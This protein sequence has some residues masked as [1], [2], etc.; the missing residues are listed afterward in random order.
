[1]KVARSSRNFA[2]GVYRS[3]NRASTGVLGPSSFGNPNGCSPRPHFEKIILK[4]LD[5]SKFLP[6]TLVCGRLKK[7]DPHRGL[8]P[9]HPPHRVHFRSHRSGNKDNHHPR[10]AS[11]IRNWNQHICSLLFTSLSLVSAVSIPHWSHLVSSMSVF[12]KLGH[13]KQFIVSIPFF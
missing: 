7:R 10:P 3:E 8:I 4:S 11:S 9:S 5:K 6:G 2:Y 1:M 12:Q 13:F